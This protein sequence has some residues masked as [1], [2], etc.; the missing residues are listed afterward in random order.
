MKLR[1]FTLVFVILT[2]AALLYGQ[3][4]VAV[5]FARGTSS[6]TVSGSVGGYKYVDYRVGA[7]GGQTMSVRLTSASSYPSFVV[8]DPTM[9][10]VDGAAEQIDWSGELPSD[11]TYTI[12]VLLPRSAAR[13]GTSARYSVRI[14][15][16]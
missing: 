6:A 12:R 9:Q 7:L 13:R 4:K 1:I 16:H 8:F 14:S 11:G 15:V 2:F 10:N 5:R 3:T